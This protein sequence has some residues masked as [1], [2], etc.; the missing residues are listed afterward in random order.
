M[1]LEQP[2]LVQL[3]LEFTA[4]FEGGKLAKLTLLPCGEQSGRS[5][6][7]S[8]IFRGTTYMVGETYEVDTDIGTIYMTDNNVKVEFVEEDFSELNE[9]LLLRMAKNLGCS[10]NQVKETVMPPAAPT[11]KKRGGRRKKAET[12][13]VET[14]KVEEPKEEVETTES[15]E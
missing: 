4:L 6:V 12:P 11:P 10:P 1:L 9:E 7:T 14:P 13:K 2:T 3:E 15:D 5:V 8:F